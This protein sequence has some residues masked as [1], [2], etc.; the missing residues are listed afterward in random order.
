MDFD[1]ETQPLG[2]DTN[3]TDVFLK[4]IWPNLQEIQETMAS[5]INKE[6]FA[7]SY[8][9]VFDGGERWKSLPTPE[10][11]IFEWDPESTYVR[12]PPYFDGMSAGARAGDGHHG[13][14]RAGQARRFGD[15]RPHLACRARSRRVPRPG[16][17]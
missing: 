14:A 15:H 4:D 7:S 12:K 10:G 17:T 9:D 16:S 13:R 1:F 8:A 6:M 3:G 2:Q 11:D 5:S